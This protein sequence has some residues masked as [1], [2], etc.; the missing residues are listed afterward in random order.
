MIATPARITPP[1]STMNTIRRIEPKHPLPVVR[2]N[3]LRVAL[4]SHDTVGLGHLR[5]NLLIADSLAQSEMQASNLLI[6]GAH[7][8]NFF[9][10]P[11][12][13][14]LFT[15]PRWRKNLSGSY[16]SGKLAI[17]QA[18][19]ARLRSA[20]ICSALDVFGPELLIV[21]KVPQGIAGELLPA[22][23]MFK[24]SGRTKLVLGLR[25]ILDA[26]HAV[27]HDWLTP[28][29]LRT[30]DRLFDAVWIY[31]DQTVYDVHREYGLPN[32]IADK[33]TYT[34]YLDRATANRRENS[35]AMDWIDTL[36]E[37][38]RLVACMV[39]GG[40]DGGPLAA[41]FSQAQFDD[42]TV[43]VLVTGPFMP[44]ATKCDL[45]AHAAKI[46]NL[47][48]ID[49]I[50]EAD[51]LLKKADRVIAMGGYNTVSSLLA[52][53]KHALIVPR[54]TPRTEQL[55]RAERLAQLG[56]IDFLHP[57]QVTVDA[58]NHWLTN[59][60]PGPRPARDLLDM[61]GLSNVCRLSA[62]LVGRSAAVAV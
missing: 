39:G 42:D 12:R 15:L 50:H 30:V 17:S 23:E 40:E 53:Q 58:L 20:S 21:D 57:E 5:R 55:I 29:N 31:G 61:N 62:S 38:K 22:L 32:A 4:Y 56:L 25:D 8:A 44:R 37:G 11:D 6:A 10:L 28:D 34:G 14:D 43:A 47:H 59:S 36:V 35:P 51:L 2:Q 1:F 52:L 33:M 27:Q 19:L 26:P 16:D 49:F 7:E 54:V 24:R 46:P 48:V 18:D 41:I 60:H 3:G 13:S 9:R 45:M